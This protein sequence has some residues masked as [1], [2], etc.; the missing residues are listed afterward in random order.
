MSCKFFL[1]PH[2]G[3]SL[4]CA[5]MCRPQA[6]RRWLG[7]ERMGRGD[8]GVRSPSYCHRCRF[9]RYSLHGPSSSFPRIAFEESPHRLSSLQEQPPVPIEVEYPEGCNVFFLGSAA[10]GTPAQVVSH[11]G[12]TVAIRIAVRLF[13]FRTDPS[14][15]CSSFALHSTSRV[16]KPKT[17]SSRLASPT[18]ASLTTRRLIR[19]AAL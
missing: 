11:G 8:R 7:V 19:S 4:F 18:C 15:V 17:Q 1:P 13:C 14:G 10:Y 16:I 6:S 9:G 3:L 2:H 5:L 12:N